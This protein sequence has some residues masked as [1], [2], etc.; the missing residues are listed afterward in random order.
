VA[1]AVNPR[2]AKNEHGRNR[3][4][5]QRADLSFRKRAGQ[6]EMVATGAVVMEDSME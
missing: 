6:A 5:P 3:R 2:A 1:P 4:N